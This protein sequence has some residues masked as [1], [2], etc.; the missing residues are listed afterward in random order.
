MARN[1]TSAL[2]SGDSLH[3]IFCLKLQHYS[4][5]PGEKMVEKSRENNSKEV[6]NGGIDFFSPN[7]SVE[8]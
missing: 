2:H 4:P 7:Q 3:K 5:C 6:L 8:A 1:L